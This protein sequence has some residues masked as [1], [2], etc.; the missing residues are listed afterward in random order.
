MISSSRILL[1]KYAALILL[2]GLLAAC[3]TQHAVSQ[4]AEAARE[5][6]MLIVENVN[7]A[8][9]KECVAGSRRT[10]MKRV[11]CIENIMQ[12][13]ALPYVS[14]P[15]LLQDMLGKTRKLAED[16]SAG[17]IDRSTFVQETN[18]AVMN[19]QRA[20]AQAWD[21]R[22]ANAS[23]IGAGDL[24]LGGIQGA[25][26]GARQRQD[27]ARLNAIINRPINCATY[28]TTAVCR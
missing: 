9:S 8:I 1:R 19:Y 18:S 6:D 15:N 16:Y 10:Q 11:G 7:A 21:A 2:S 4:Q 12:R 26:Q 3:E 20:V 23:P 14:Y 5:Q 13:D 28:G 25:A 27:N 17:S 24:L 22:I